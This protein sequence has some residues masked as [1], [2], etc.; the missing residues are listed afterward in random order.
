MTKIDLIHHEYQKAFEFEW[1]RGDLLSAKA[2]KYIIT[3]GLIIGFGLFRIPTIHELLVIQ[4]CQLLIG[5]C[6]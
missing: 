5:R 2:E 1:K 4:T 6:L 3:I